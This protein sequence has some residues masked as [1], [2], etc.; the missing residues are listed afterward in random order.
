MG[1]SLAFL[2]ISS[3]NALFWPPLILMVVDSCWS[4]GCQE[5]RVKCWRLF[6]IDAGFGLGKL[7]KWENAS[8]EHIC[9]AKEQH[10]QSRL[11]NCWY[12]DTDVFPQLEAVN[13]HNLYLVPLVPGMLEVQ[14]LH[15]SCPKEVTTCNSLGRR[16]SLMHTA[17]EQCFAKLWKQN[18]SPSRIKEGLLWTSRQNQRGTSTVPLSIHSLRKQW[19]N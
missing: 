6:H 15:S 18:I 7:R 12:P 17:K 13:V 9:K 16:V 3:L 19:S 2:T 1:L 14:W 5:C 10:F 11:S 8:R 4:W